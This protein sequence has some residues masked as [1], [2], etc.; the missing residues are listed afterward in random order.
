MRYP[1]VSAYVTTLPDGW[2]SFAACEVNASLIFGLRERGVFDG[3]EGLPDAIASLIVGPPPES[4]WLPE[5]ISVGVFLAVRDARFGGPAGEV[6]FLAWVDAL[7]HEILHVEQSAL[8][9]TTPGDA[10]RFIPEVWARFHRGSTMTVVA[11][12]K[13]TAEVAFAHPTFLFPGQWMESRRRTLVSAL[14]RAGAAQPSVRAAR[15]G[16]RGT[17]FH[18][19]WR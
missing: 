13:Q 5:V 3:L 12:T 1:S 4:G 19:S 2:S 16:D 11:Q 8:L 6:D 15:D 9:V 17:R 10:V 7:N 18:L 14:V